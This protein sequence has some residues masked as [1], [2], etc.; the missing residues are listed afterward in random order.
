MEDDWSSGGTGSVMHGYFRESA[1]RAWFSGHPSSAATVP[2]VFLFSSDGNRSSPQYIGP[3]P[4]PSYS[5][6]AH[7]VGHFI[8]WQYGGWSGPAGTKLASS[9]NEGHSMVLAALLGKQHFGA[10]EYEES[11]YVTT[12]GK[13]DGRQWS[14][15]VYGTTPLKYS[16]M[17]C[18]D[19]DP[20]YMAWPFVQALWRLMNNRGPGD[21]PIWGDDEAAIANT[22]D[23]FMHS[24]HTFTAD[25]TMT[26]DKL[27]LGLL[28]RL[29]DR[30]TDG[31]EQAPLD[32]TYCDVYSVF[33]QHDLLT[34]CRN[35]P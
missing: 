16:A 34:R 30:I 4:S 8:S 18:V 33:D 10:L 13:T 28:A 14:H 11:E 5:I 31:T 32:N 6:V 19:D 27:C 2:A 7:E 9:L 23:L 24:L 20:Y 17:D 25:S 21:D 15:F 29:Y 12:G 26:W 35:S 3:E 1:P 22:A